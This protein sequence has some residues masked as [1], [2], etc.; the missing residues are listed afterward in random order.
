M[1]NS[2]SNSLEDFETPPEINFKL[3]T[4]AFSSSS[5]SKTEIYF[6][7]AKP[8]VLKLDSNALSWV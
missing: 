4:K 7:N 8:C 6:F 2:N 1:K 3:R 5:N